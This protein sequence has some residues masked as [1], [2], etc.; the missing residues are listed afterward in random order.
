V[1]VQVFRRN[2]GW[3]VKHYYLGDELTLPSIDLTLSVAEIRVQKWSF[4]SI[5]NPNKKTV[6]AIRKRLRHQVELEKR[7]FPSRELGNETMFDFFSKTKEASLMN[8]I[9]KKQCHKI[10]HA[11]AASGGTAA[12]GMAQLPG[13]DVTVL[14]GIEIA[15]TISLGAVFGISL[16][17]SSAKSIVLA[18]TAFYAGRGISQALVGWIPGFGNLINASTAVTLIEA[19]GW[20]GE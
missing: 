20:V 7:A 11:A 14:V 13:A 2:E 9:Q 16:T 18:T 10:I 3:L 4:W 5:I 1:N 12:A 19:M 6:G 15:M 17:E 8:E